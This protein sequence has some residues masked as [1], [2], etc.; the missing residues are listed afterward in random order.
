MMHSDSSIQRS[1]DEKSIDFI[2]LLEI[3]NQLIKTAVSPEDAYAQGLKLICSTYNWPVGHV[4]QMDNDNGTLISSKIWHLPE[5]NE[6]DKFRELTESTTFIKGM[7]L[8]GR[9]LQSKKAEWIIDV[10]QDPNFP[11]A[12]QAEDIGVKAAFAFPISV[13]GQIKAVWEFYS[14]EAFEPDHK[15]LIVIDAV[16]SQISRVLELFYEKEYRERAIMIAKKS[17]Q[18]VEEIELEIE[19]FTRLNSVIENGLSGMNDVI[20]RIKMVSINASIEAS[21][22]GANGTRLN[23]IAIEIERMSRDITESG[24]TIK[25]EVSHSQKNNEKLI[26]RIRDINDLLKEVQGLSE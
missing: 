4:Y 7:G 16:G 10:T 17:K 18:M 6:F 2:K 11:R 9:V 25:E 8:P 23:V 5:I 12:K 19:H 13:G 24:D 26:S 21:K 3:S 20:R 15:L 14:K 1:L 22:L